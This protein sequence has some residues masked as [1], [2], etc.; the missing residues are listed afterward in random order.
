[1]IDGLSLMSNGLR[2]GLNVPQALQI[3]TEELP[4]PISQEFALVL[5]QNKLGVTLEDA[6]GNAHGQ[7]DQIAGLGGG[8]LAI[9]HQIKIAFQHANEF[10]LRGVDMRR[11]EGAGRK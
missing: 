8:S 10:I 6:M 11:H 5:S 4:N 3:V 7:A 2:S 1:M 9:Q